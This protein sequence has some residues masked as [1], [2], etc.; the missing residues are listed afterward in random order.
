MPVGF[1]RMHMPVG[2]VSHWRM[3]VGL[4]EPCDGCARRGLETLLRCLPSV[5]TSW[6]QH[7]GAA[8]QM[9]FFTPPVFCA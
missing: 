6:M 5:S 1:V 4:G 7:G 8:L 9:V 2:F 3:H